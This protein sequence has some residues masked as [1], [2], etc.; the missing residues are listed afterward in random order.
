[1][2]E[3]PKCRK[4]RRVIAF[5]TTKTGKQM[6]VDGFSVSIIPY[7]RGSVF[8]KDTGEQIRGYT[9]PAGTPGAVRAYQPHWSTCA[10]GDE[11]PRK[12][13]DKR[14]ENIRAQVERDKAIEAKRQ[15]RREEKAAKAEAIREIEE[16]Q[17]SLFGGYTPSW[18]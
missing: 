3:P 1:M 2:Y 4:C 8:Y 11:L 16:A 14:R 5:V 6:P 7:I 10:H 13:T 18:R 15:E 9:V 17:T 12:K